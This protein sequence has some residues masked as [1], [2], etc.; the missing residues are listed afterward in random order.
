MK[1]AEAYGPGKF[2]LVMNGVAQ[3]AE[4]RCGLFL[5][6]G[7]PEIDIHFGVGGRRLAGEALTHHQGHG[8]LMPA[9]AGLRLTQRPAAEVDAASTR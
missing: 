3:I 8:L 5:N 4:A 6:P 1:I 7:P 2:G 9:H